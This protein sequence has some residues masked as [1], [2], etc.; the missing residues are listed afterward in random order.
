MAKLEL[1]R[2]TGSDGGCHLFT[3]DP[4]GLLAWGRTVEEAMTA[5]PQE[6]R[7]LRRFL[8][9][10][11]RQGL[12]R[13]VWAEGETPDLVVVETV[14]GRWQVA[15][16]GTKATFERDLVPVET[17]EIPGFLDILRQMRV[18]LLELRDRIP[19]EAH[20]FRSLPHRMT[21]GEQL[22]HIASCDRWYL[23]RFWRCV[24][25][26][27]RSRNVWHKLELNR[28]LALDLLGNLRGDDLSVARKTDY[29]IWT[30]RKLFRRF[31]YHEKFHFGTIERDLALYLEDRE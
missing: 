2:E 12:L 5:A 20:D 3:F 13:E 24:P 29:Q 31:M 16:G 26:L 7:E 17:R 21:I 9:A 27:P 6:A 14:A 10:C 23:T 19:V 28:E 11:G 15:N 4:P 30:A 1:Y 18:I 8:A 22:R 25:A